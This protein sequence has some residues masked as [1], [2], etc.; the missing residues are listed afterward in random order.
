MADQVVLLTRFEREPAAPTRALS[1]G[2]GSAVA[3]L[4]R[5]GP[6]VDEGGPCVKALDR[7][8]RRTVIEPGRVQEA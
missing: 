5:S 3:T 8:E 7:L 1:F 2:E 6:A 4:W